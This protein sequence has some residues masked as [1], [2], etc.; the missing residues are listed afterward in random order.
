MTSRFDD[1]LLDDVNLT[2]TAAPW[3]PGVEGPGMYMT[4]EE[5]RAAMFAAR[6][7]VPAGFDAAAWHEAQA[8]AWGG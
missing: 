3:P 5:R 4:V 1:S 2:G 7:E 6:D 8:G